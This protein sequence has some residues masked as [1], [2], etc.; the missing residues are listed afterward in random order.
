MFY[1]TIDITTLYVVLF[2]YEDLDIWPLPDLQGTEN[3]Y[4]LSP[5]RAN[6]QKMK[7]LL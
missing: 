6:S 4:H 7:F 2:D 3:L 5:I 1:K